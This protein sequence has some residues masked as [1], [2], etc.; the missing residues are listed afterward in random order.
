MVSP[1][2]RKR[3]SNSTNDTFEESPSGN[4][5]KVARDG[6]GNL[7]GLGPEY[8]ESEFFGEKDDGNQSRI[9]RAQEKS[10]KV[11]KIESS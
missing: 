1:Q 2:K 7:V 8:T 3:L 4:T 11:Q 10:R 5:H 6:Q 9:A